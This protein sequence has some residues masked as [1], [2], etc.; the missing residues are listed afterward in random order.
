MSSSWRITDDILVIVSAAE[1]PRRRLPTI[2]KCEKSL[3]L[4]FWW[5]FWS[6][7]QPCVAG[8]CDGSGS[9]PLQVCRCCWVG[10]SSSLGRSCP[11]AVWGQGRHPVLWMVLSP[12]WCFG[13]VLLVRTGEN[14]RF[15]SGWRRA[16]GKL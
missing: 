13:V 8:G 11:W 12:P 3:I 5:F 6:G 15:C 4:P 7:T 16:G 14:Q 10:A 2:Q 9:V 1:Q